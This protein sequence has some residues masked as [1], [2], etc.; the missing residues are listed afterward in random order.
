MSHNQMIESIIVDQIFQNDTFKY[1]YP[2]IYIFL[3][4]LMRTYVR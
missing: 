2:R 1:V 3:M 4:E